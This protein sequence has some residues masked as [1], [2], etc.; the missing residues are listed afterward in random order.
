MAVM[1]IDTASPATVTSSFRNTRTTT[2]SAK[3]ARSTFPIHLHARDGLRLT[4]RKVSRRLSR[5]G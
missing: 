2:R 1:T 5:K 3:A 4:Y